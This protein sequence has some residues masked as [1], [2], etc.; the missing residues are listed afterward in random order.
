MMPTAEQYDARA[1]AHRPTS[2]YAMAVEIRRLHSTGLQ[3]RDL[4]AALR[5]DLTQVLQAI[6]EPTS[7]GDPRHGQTHSDQ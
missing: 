1:N 2:I 3:P 7:T 6:T 5:L 4:A